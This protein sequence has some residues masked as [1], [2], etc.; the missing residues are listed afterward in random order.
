MAPGSAAD[1]TMGSRRLAR[2]PAAVSGAVGT[3]PEELSGGSDQRHRRSLEGPDGTA[4]RPAPLL[5]GIQ[6]TCQGDAVLHALTRRGPC[7]LPLRVCE[8]IVE[9]SRPW[10]PNLTPEPV[11]SERRLRR[12]NPL[13][14][15]RSGGG[16]RGPLP[17]RSRRL[18]ADREERRIGVSERCGHALVQGRA[19]RRVIRVRPEASGPA[20]R[21]RALAPLPGDRASGRGHDQQRS[22][23]QSCSFPSLHTVSPRIPWSSRPPPLILPSAVHSMTR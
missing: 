9:S 13:S 20:S 18:R 23:E 11:R 8:P 6:R 19:A 17:L 7:V 12:R 14:R 22:Q 3:N 4:V 2:A 16:R 10:R 15:G 21:P 1:Q 5:T